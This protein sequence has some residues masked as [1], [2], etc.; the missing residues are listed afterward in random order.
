[1]INLEVWVPP[2]KDM[3]DILR[4]TTVKEYGNLRSPITF[5]WF[6]PKSLTN[7][8]TMIDT[9]WRREYGAV[10]WTMFKRKDFIA[11]FE[12]TNET[13]RIEIEKLSRTNSDKQT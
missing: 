11:A 2:H 7:H 5:G 12:I 13:L 10:Q 8:I 1:M 9:T 3:V 4:S 6:I